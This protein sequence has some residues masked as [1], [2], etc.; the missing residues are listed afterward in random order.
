MVFVIEICVFIPEAAPSFSHHHPPHHAYHHSPQCHII[1]LPY[2]TFSLTGTQTSPHSSHP[3]KRY[4]TTTLNAF[5]ATL[6]NHKTA[7]EL[8][9]GGGGEYQEGTE[10]R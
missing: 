3:P 6:H 2:Q 5:L 10:Q 8:E 4:G 7:D 1:P 9:T